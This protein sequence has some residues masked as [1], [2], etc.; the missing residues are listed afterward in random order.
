MKK[1]KVWQLV[2]GLVLVVSGSVLFAI[3]VSGGF[4]SGESKA[5]LDEEYICEGCEFSYMDLESEEY[6][7]LI[8]NKKSFIVMIDQGG[9][10]TANT[11]KGF[12]KDFATDKGIKVYKMMYG[13]MRKTSM[14]DFVKYYPS[15]AV[16][17]DGKVIGWLKAN[18]DEDSDAYNQYEAFET[19][20]NQYLK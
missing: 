1:L 13:D 2:V 15:V 14:Y 19:W 18:S 9:C 11:L 20:V 17:S 5:V 12:V 7:E 6:E 3:G 16:V 4:G 8:T 10:S